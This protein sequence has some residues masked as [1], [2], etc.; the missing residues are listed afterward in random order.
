VTIYPK[1][2]SDGTTEADPSQSP[3]GVAAAPKFPEIEERVLAFWR[4]DGTF[5]ASV[6]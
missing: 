3:V 2:T 1:A 6:A 5:Q 4:A